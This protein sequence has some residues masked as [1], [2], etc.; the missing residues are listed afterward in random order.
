MTPSLRKKPKRVQKKRVRDTL[1][2]KEE[3][4]VGT[5]NEGG[6][7]PVVA[8]TRAEIEGYRSQIG[9]EQK[10]DVVGP[11]RAHLVSLYAFGSMDYP[12]RQDWAK[13]AAKLAKKMGA[14]GE[15]SPEEEKARIAADLANDVEGSIERAQ[16]YGEEHPQRC[17]PLQLQGYARLKH[18]TK[19]AR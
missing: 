15:L 19:R 14:E 8:A 4:T 17:T 13:N 10:D 7:V 9:K 2:E 18:E 1:L 12:E 11:A 5:A 6:I 3:I 16:K